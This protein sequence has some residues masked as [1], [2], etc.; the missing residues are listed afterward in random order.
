MSDI[1]LH[2]GGL[3]LFNELSVAPRRLCEATVVAPWTFSYITLA[4]TLTQQMKGRTV[5]RR[6]SRI[7]NENAR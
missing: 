7:H 5:A 3:S 1:V 2:S 6:G 4:L